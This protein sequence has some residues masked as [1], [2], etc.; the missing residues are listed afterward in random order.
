MRCSGVSPDTPERWKCTSQIRGFLLVVVAPEKPGLAWEN[1]SG[2]L[3]ATV[4]RRIRRLII[5]V[6]SAIQWLGTPAF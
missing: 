5:F 1:P 4:F 2:Q 3:L 6:C